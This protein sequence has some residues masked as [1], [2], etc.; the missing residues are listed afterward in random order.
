MVFA[1]WKKLGLA[2]LV[3]SSLT[4]TAWAASD[5]LVLS[6]AEDAPTADPGVEIS[7]S[8]YTFIY[9]AYEHLV[10][11]KGA[12][13]EVVP[14]LAESWSVDDTNT[15]WTFKLA[16]GHK[17][18]DGTPVDA[19]AV[20]FSFDRA[21][22]LKAGPSDAFPVLKEV[23]VVDPGTVKFILS[24]QFAPFLS[25]MA[26]SGAAIINPKVMEHEKDGDMAKA[27]LAEHTAGSGAYKITSWERNQ[28][29]VLDRNEHYAGSTPALKQIV[30]RTVG[31]ISARRLQLVN[32]DADI[33][34]QVPVDQAAA[35]KGDP[36]IVVESNPSLYVNY[37]Y[38]NNKRP[39]LDDA[40]V[41][42]AISYAVDYK[43]I[44]DGI[45]QGQAEQMRGAVPDGM[46]A[47]D[48][49]G[50]QY[51]YDV[52]KAKALLKEAGKSDIHLTYTFSQADTAWE[53]VGLALQ[54]N[55]AD[56]GIK[57]D[58]QAVADTTKREMAASGNYDLAPGAWT[59]D[60]AD[61]YMFMNYWFD[62][63]RM[64]GPGNRAFYNN[65]KVA[66]LV[67]EAASIIDQPK[68]EQLYLEAQK[69]STQ[70]APYLYLMQKNDIFARRAV[71]KGYV[72][73]PMLI[74][75]YNFATM[76]KSE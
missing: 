5:V 54:A 58:L 40:R 56:I 17:F 71:V 16:Q 6:R 67:R 18:D 7:N 31:E 35:L 75:V 57:L 28:S 43:G 50:F 34:E 52:E 69:L 63:D 25:T 37:V 70:D 51:S 8:G 66:G 41:R 39:P 27:W 33:I 55:L 4:Q 32:G 73:N 60:F 65:P 29:V 44:V 59:P 9:A 30:V 10:A 74:Q 64:G 42:Q 1:H 46:W 47:H 49:N 15:V 21:M 48:P 2:L 24:S 45:M 3:T 38:M 36:N 22:K 26:V 11:Y 20:K 68:R 12:T 62:P 53:P 72:Y 23:Q 61:P 14:E 13:T 19:A 76:S